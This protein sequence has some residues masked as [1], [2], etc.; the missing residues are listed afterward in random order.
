MSAKEYDSSSTSNDLLERLMAKY[1]P[2]A[3]N[4]QIIAQSALDVQNVNCAPAVS[5]GPYLIQSDQVRLMMEISIY[6]LP[7]ASRE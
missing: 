7:G 6:S 2:E 3:L 4:Y 1:P 5:M